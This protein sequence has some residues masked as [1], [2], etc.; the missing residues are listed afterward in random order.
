MQLNANLIDTGTP[1]IPEAQ[2]WLRW[3][4]AS[5]DLGRLTQGVDRL[6]QWLAKA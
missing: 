1:P 3:C 6:Q 4:F 2:G 5:R